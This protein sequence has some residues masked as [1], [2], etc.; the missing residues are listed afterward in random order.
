MKIFLNLPEPIET[1]INETAIGYQIT[2]NR[3]A[4]DLDL[5]KKLKLPIPIKLSDAL[6]KI[7]QLLENII[8]F[9]GMVV[10]VPNKLASARD[11]EIE[12]THKE[13][14]LIVYI[15]KNKGASKDDLLKNLWGYS[16]DSVS[17]TVETHISR[18]NGKFE[19]E[20]GCELIVNQNGLYQLKR[21]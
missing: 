9:E 20:F 18:L 11:R 19:E 4:A 14:E 7:S 6:A 12:L 8:F 13:L 2:Q 3:E 16:A 15:N 17:N 10:D 5:A 1:A 21:I